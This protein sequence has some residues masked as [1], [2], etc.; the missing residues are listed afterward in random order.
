MKTILLHLQ[1]YKFILTYDILPS[2]DFQLSSNDGFSVIS[3]GS[4]LPKGGRLLVSLDFHSSSNE[5]VFQAVS[6]DIGASFPPAGPVGVLYTSFLSINIEKA[7]HK[8]LFP[9]KEEFKYLC[10]LGS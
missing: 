10:K 3:G 7:W 5:G 9:S 8:I 1:N 4:L 6:S 2:L